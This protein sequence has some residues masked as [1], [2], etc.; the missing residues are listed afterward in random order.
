[1]S[2]ITDIILLTFIRDREANGGR[3]NAEK[4]SEYLS[5]NYRSNGFVQVDGYAGGNRAMQ[6]NVFI[7]AVNYLDHD[8]FIEVFNS[9]EWEY[10]ESVQLLLKCEDCDTFEIIIPVLP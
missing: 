8:E 3:L 6:C 4:L 2:V 7:T 5:E 10:P 9:I 1:M